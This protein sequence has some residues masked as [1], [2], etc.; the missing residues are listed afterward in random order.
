MYSRTYLEWAATLSSI[1]KWSSAI[2]KNNY[3]QQ[4]QQ[5]EDLEKTILNYYRC[6]SGQ[7]GEWVSVTNPLNY[8]PQPIFPSSFSFALHF[9]FV[10][11]MPMQSITV[12]ELIRLKQC[13][14]PHLIYPTLGGV[15]GLG[16][17]RV[18]P[19]H[20]ITHSHG[21]CGFHV[22]FLITQFQLRNSALKRVTSQTF[23]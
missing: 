4:Q 9:T 6:P 23:S 15:G 1:L 22:H 19:S 14:A 20:L 2:R 17:Q 21:N 5:H 3:Q 8:R 12:S 16:F 18:N 10:H 11:L 13:P 7:T